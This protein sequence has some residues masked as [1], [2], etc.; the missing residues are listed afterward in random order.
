MSIWGVDNFERDDAMN[1]LDRWNEQLVNEVQETFLRKN[2]KSLYEDYGESRIIGNIDI[3]AT[4]L[5]RYKNYPHITIDEVNIWKQ[6][7][8]DTYDRT[9]DTY[10]PTDEFKKHRREKIEET[11]NRLHKIVYEI[12]ED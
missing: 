7:Y 4:L 10:E 1:V 6:T 2:D 8:L 12:I 11:F 9:I 3:L 5:E